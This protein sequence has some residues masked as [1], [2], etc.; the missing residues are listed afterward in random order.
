MTT[1]TSTVDNVIIA[2]YKQ[3]LPREKHH[4]IIL[5]IIIPIVWIAFIASFVWAKR[6][7][8]VI[9]GILHPFTNWSGTGENASSS[10]ELTNVSDA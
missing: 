3:L 2:S 9:N 8:G 5:A 10:Y 7:S 1:T 4:I 6:S